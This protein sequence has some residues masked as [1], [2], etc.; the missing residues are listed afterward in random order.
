MLFVKQKTEAMHV[1]WPTL[2]SIIKIWQVCRTYGQAFRHM[3]LESWFM[4]HF[5]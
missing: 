3:S 4:D 1:E 5:F 2:K